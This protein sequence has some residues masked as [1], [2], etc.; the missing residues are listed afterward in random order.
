[1]TSGYRT[2]FAGINCA[3]LPAGVRTME[4]AGSPWRQSPLHSSGDALLLTALFLS[5]IWLSIS[6]LLMTCQAGTSAIRRGPSGAVQREVTTRSQAR[7]PWRH[8]GQRTDPPV[9]ATSLAATLER[10]SR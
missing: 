1:M 5:R 9:A 6:V 2:S 8:A 7:D 10:P 4:G 3:G